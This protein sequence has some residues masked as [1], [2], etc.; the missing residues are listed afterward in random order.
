MSPYPADGSLPENAAVEPAGWRK[1]SCSPSGPGAACVQAMLMHAVPGPDGLMLVKVGSPDPRALAGS[2]P[3]Q[4]QAGPYQLESRSPATKRQGGDSVSGLLEAPR[5]PRDDGLDSTA[6]APRYLDGFEPASAP[7]DAQAPASGAPEE[8]ATRSVAREA[9]SGDGRLSPPRVVA[10]VALSLDELRARVEQV[11]SLGSGVNDC[12]LLVQAL[13]RKLFPAGLRTSGTADDIRLGVVGPDLLDPTVA[14]VRRAEQV[15][16]AGARWQPVQDWPDLADRVRR[17]E[18]G[19]VAVVLSGQ[20]REVGHAWMIY[21]TS[22]REVVPIELQA[23]VGGQVDVTPVPGRLL[24]DARAI[25]A[26]VHGRIQ[27]ETPATRPSTTTDV[28]ALTDPSTNL[29]TAGPRPRFDTGQPP[30]TDAEIAQVAAAMVELVGRGGPSGGATLVAHLF[31][32]PGG[33]SRHLDSSWG[34]ARAAH[35]GGGMH[36]F[37]DD[38]GRLLMAI[39]FGLL[40][41]VD[42]QGKQVYTQAQIATLI[43]V[44]EYQVTQWLATSAGSG[45]VEKTKLEI[46]QVVTE[47][48]TLMREGGPP[49]GMTLEAYLFRGTDS[50][51]R[52][53]GQ[54]WGPARTGSARSRLTSNATRLLKAIAAHLL[55]GVDARRGLIYGQAEVAARVGVSTTVL[56]QWQA[57]GLASQRQAGVGVPGSSG[58]QDPSRPSQT[59]PYGIPGPSRTQDP[60]RP[61]QAGPYGVPGPSRM[62]VPSQSGMVTQGSVLPGS[63]SST[64][65]IGVPPGPVVVPV[66]ADGWC[67]IASVLAG[68][69][70]PARAR[71]AERLR[72]SDPRLGMRDLVAEYLAAAPQGRVPGE[73]ARAYRE[74]HLADLQNRILPLNNQWLTAQAQSL[75]LAVPATLERGGR[76]R[77]QA[78]VLEARRNGPL[79]GREHA[80]LLAAVRNWSQE[81]AAPEGEAFAPL[82]AN[83]LGIR[84]RIRW[85]D[86]AWQAEYGPE[87]GEPVQVLYHPSTSHYDAIAIRPAPGPGAGAAGPSTS[88][89]AGGWEPRTQS[90]TEAGQSDIE[91]APS[92]GSMPP[93]GEHARVSKRRNDDRQSQSPPENGQT[94]KSPRLE[95][96]QR[97]AVSPAPLRADQRSVVSPPAAYRPQPGPTVQQQLDYAR[98]HYTRD[99]PNEGI[100]MSWVSRHPPRYV[101]SFDN[102]FPLRDLRDPVNRVHRFYADDGGGVHPSVAVGDIHMV[103]PDAYTR[104]VEPNTRRHA[105]L[106]R[107]WK[108]AVRKELQRLIDGRVQPLPVTVRTLTDQ[109][110]QPHERAA[111]TGQSGLFLAPRLDR[112]GRPIDPRA[113]NGEILGLYAGALMLDRADEQYWA[114]TYGDNF[115]HYSVHLGYSGSSARA[116]ASIAGEGATNAIGFANTALLPGLGPARYDRSRLNAF[117]AVFNVQLRDRHGVWHWQR[118]PA[119]LGQNNLGPGHQIYADYE[120][121]YLPLFDAHSSAPTVKTEEPPTS[122]PPSGHGHTQAFMVDTS[123]SMHR[124]IHAAL[125]TLRRERETTT[126]PAQRE[127]K[128]RQIR[129]LEGRAASWDRTTTHDRLAHHGEVAQVVG[130]AGQVHPATDVPHAIAGVQAESGAT[131]DAGEQADDRE[132]EVQR[133]TSRLRSGAPSGWPVD[134]LRSLRNA[135]SAHP[136]IDVD[137]KS[138]IGWSSSQRSARNDNG[139]PIPKA[140][141]ACVEVTVIPLWA[142]DGRTW[143]VPEP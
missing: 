34:P 1:A 19:A 66:P 92:D 132:A 63:V 37:T 68:L 117:F 80:A 133:Q 124:G 121:G 87:T 40:R 122:P 72:R 89:R 51:P 116:P 118:V 58:T 98:E 140:E 96:G 21:H 138:G 5:S 114:N 20:G 142:A 54:S 83:A 4:W 111:L 55:S 131:A 33:T 143:D 32:E 36:G 45:V 8:Q 59:G 24:R 48:V 39:M 130:P 95:N 74:P 113:A 109:D 2:L 76:E 91:M 85:S 134:A 70:G 97:A 11:S 43:G 52:H 62:Q 3:G 99:F 100:T 28:K 26:D 88:V 136:H 112:H 77:L 15:L 47:M 16:A 12:V 50:I 38:A 61:S 115:P 103:N 10:G 75:G 107:A 127:R 25:L 17:A 7:G 82:L 31:G 101:Q 128:D 9:V 137:P 35:A 84:L 69:S 57:S 23:G 106:H 120:A 119:L 22:T 79:S 29:R 139:E 94:A 41:R 86:S 13:V 71:V 129:Q 123:D 126:D 135:R 78:S 81:W 44:P 90:R 105:E 65:V 110:L 30:K 49:N 104:D 73:V 93:S 102:A 67:L 56:A 18:P 14:G 46:E 60:S 6:A 64:G 108:E 42:A 141:R 27:D 125:D 53:L